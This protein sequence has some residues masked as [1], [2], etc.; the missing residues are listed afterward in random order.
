M[1]P[2]HNIKLAIYK[3]IHRERANTCVFGLY[4]IEIE[5][6]LLFFSLLFQEKWVWVYIFL[7]LFVC[8]GGQFVCYGGLMA[9]SNWERRWT[10]LVWGFTKREGRLIWFGGRWINFGFLVLIW[11]VVRVTCE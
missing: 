4:L 10:D 11:G 2:T 3:D 7:G 6:S 8:D 1:A 5:I 9:I